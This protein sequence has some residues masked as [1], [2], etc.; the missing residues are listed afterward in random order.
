MAFDR[1]RYALGLVG[2]DVFPVKLGEGCMLCPCGRP[3]FVMLRSLET[4]EE[5]ET[6]AWCYNC[7]EG[8][9]IHTGVFD[10]PRALKAY[11]EWRN[12]QVSPA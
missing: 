1:I 5:S 4:I 3:V 10:D 11:K 9:Q 6:W 8:M 7:R 12:E 2:K